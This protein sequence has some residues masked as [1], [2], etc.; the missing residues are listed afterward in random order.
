MSSGPPDDIA[1]DG[2]WR[3]L[4][5]EVKPNFIVCARRC[6]TAA[7]AHW[8]ADLSLSSPQSG[9]CAVS[10]TGVTAE[11]SARHALGMGCRSPQAR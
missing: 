8:I 11:P 1:D 7:V 3:S 6:Q 5:A 9:R 10:A 2:Y 4:L